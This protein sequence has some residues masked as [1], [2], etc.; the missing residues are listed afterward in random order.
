[1]LDDIAENTDT[2]L[3]DRIVFEETF[4][5][6]DF[7]DRYN[8]YQGSA[9]GLAHPP[10]DFA[11]SPAPPGPTRSTGSTSRS[12]TTPVSVSRCVSSADS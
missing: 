4:C 11:A 12:T 2:E 6:D 5:V 8:S 3:R 1:V 7:A 9:L 10:T